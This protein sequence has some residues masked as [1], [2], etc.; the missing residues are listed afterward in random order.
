MANVDDQI[1]LLFKQSFPGLQRCLFYIDESNS[2]VLFNRYVISRL[3]EC[4]VVHRYGDDRTF[5]FN[6]LKNA[7]VWCILDNEDKF[8]EA[9]RVSELD[10]LLISVQMDKLIHSRLNKRGD[11]YGRAINAAKLQYDCDKERLFQAEL[12]KYTILARDCQQRRFEHETNRTGRK[13]KN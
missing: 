1:A 9:R 11:V 3:N 5:R 7:T 2:Y 12:N 4:R 8:Y 6:S 13:Q 10:S